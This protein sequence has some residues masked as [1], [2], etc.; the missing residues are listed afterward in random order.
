MEK[1]KV[2]RYMTGKRPDWAPEEFDSDEELTIQT[3]S[4]KIK[5]P[6]KLADGEETTNQNQD[7]L[8]DDIKPEEAATDRR[9]ARLMRHQAEKDE[10]DEADYVSRHHR[11]EPELLDD[12][13][14]SSDEEPE[15]EG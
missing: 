10:D 2:T 9:L 6:G 14:Q 15:D 13:Q 4:I 8:T 3:K 11:T 7:S 1:V 5:V 12:A